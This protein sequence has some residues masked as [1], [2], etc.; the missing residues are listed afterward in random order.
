V[1]G[2]RLLSGNQVARLADNF[3]RRAG[4][5]IP[6]YDV[7]GKRLPDYYRVR[8]LE[9][10]SGFDRLTDVPKYVQPTGTPPRA[11]FPPTLAWSEILGSRAPLLITE[12]EL[13]AACAAKFGFHAIGL[14]GV[15]AWK[16]KRLGT[17]FL[18]ELADVDW[19]ERVVFLAFDSDI[20]WKPPVRL[21]LTALADELLARGARPFQVMLP[22]LASGKTGLDDFLV[23]RGPGALETLFELSQ[24]YELS[25]E[26]WR[27]SNEVAWVR[28]PGVVVKIQTGQRMSY[29]AFLQGHY[30]NRWLDVTKV[31]ANQEP[32]VVR[33]SLAKEWFTWE[34][35]AELEG[36]AYEP[37]QATITQ[38][39]AYNLWRGWGVAPVRGSIAPWKAL[40]RYLFNQDEPKL[41]WF[42]RWCAIQLQRPG[43][44]LYSAALLWGRCQ[45]TGKSLVG[46]TLGRLFG[47]NFKE[48]HT[49]DLYSR[50]NDWAASTQFVLGDEIGA[51]SAQSSDR[52]Q[53]GDIVKR[54][55]TRETIRVNQK[56]LPTFEIDDRINYLFTSNHPN[57]FYIEP[58]D[59]RFFVHEVTEEP[60]SDTFYKDYD[61]WYRGVGAAHLFYYLASLDLGD[62]N[63]RAPAFATPDKQEMVRLSASDIDA[64]LM[65][66]KAQPYELLETLGIDD[67]SDVWT[68]EQL[69]TLYDPTGRT[70]LTSNGLAR[71]LKKNG[72]P[73]VGGERG[74]TMTRDGLKRF[75][76]VANFQHWKSVKPKR[77]AEH[78][79]K[80][81]SQASQV[82]RKKQF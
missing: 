51:S 35:R 18:P 13:K 56:Y 74:T 31:G 12:G 59:R 32:R 82:G 71:L 48:I 49:E 39:G 26:L 46:Y 70:R 6:Y 5:L 2:I 33:R 76:A 16:S 25:R 68:A 72:F 28:D 45:G 50:Y 36:I 24:E 38:A 10:P 77:I 75:Y 65:E 4:I 44:K 9:A 41:S 8:Y 81:F 69:K 23:A 63:A 15:Y 17:S 47:Q 60:K 21:A 20:H 40:L 57:A 7:S 14:G 22:T 62:F 42:E 29:Q 54:L 53:S 78:Y 19:K 30:A 43:I 67:P 61:L 27:L 64:W 79:H 34:H 1:L 3:R 55:I 11:Y 52:R 58:G 73:N 80:H 37:G 66:L